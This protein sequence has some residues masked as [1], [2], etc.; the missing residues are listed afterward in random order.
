MQKWDFCRRIADQETHSSRMDSLG[1]LC[2]ERVQEVSVRFSSKIVSSFAIS[3]YGD[4]GLLSNKARYNL[5]SPI[6]IP[7]LPLPC[8]DFQ[9]RPLDQ[10]E[11]QDCS[12]R[13]A[14]TDSC[15][16]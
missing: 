8:L 6:Q 15:G 7:A 10:A 16:L 9:I 4:C 1:S 3:E 2:L 11:T 5:E 14:P 13:D 12:G